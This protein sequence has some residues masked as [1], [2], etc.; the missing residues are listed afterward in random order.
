MED[1]H[2]RYICNQK[3]HIFAFIGREQKTFNAKETSPVAGSNDIHQETES[4]LEI[5]NE[6]CALRL[7]RQRGCAVIISNSGYERQ[8]RLHVRAD[9][10]RA[11]GVY[12]TESVGDVR[13]WNDKPK[14]GGRSRTNESNQRFVP[15][16]STKARCSHGLAA[17]LCQSENGFLA[18]LQCEIRRSYI[19]ATPVACSCAYGK[20]KRQKKQGGLIIHS[21]VKF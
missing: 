3:L 13:R 8:H 7:D 6:I 10:A 18:S 12:E 17:P 1:L 11:E 2:Q 21:I 15:R 16:S 9:R 20:E 19:R 4:E 5:A 14:E